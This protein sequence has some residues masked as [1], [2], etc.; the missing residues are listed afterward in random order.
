M[1]ELKPSS[2]PR[3]GQPGHSVAALAAAETRHAREA[4]RF[5]GA[6][7][8]TFGL[9]LGVGSSGSAATAQTERARVFA[10]PR[11]LRLPFAQWPTLALAAALLTTPAWLGL[12]AKVLSGDRDLDLTAAHPLLWGFMTVA[13]MAV[14]CLALLD[15]VVRA[16]RQDAREDA[17]NEDRPAR[18]ARYAE[19]RYCGGCHAVFDGEGRSEPADEAG[20]GRMM[21]A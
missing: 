16:K 10:P 1:S 20:F 12:A 15:L 17:V 6:I 9:G 13:A 7:A 14:G 8:G 2:C 18:Q 19:L 4:G 3:C 11:P 5:S 21:G